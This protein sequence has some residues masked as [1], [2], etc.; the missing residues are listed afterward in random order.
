MP[1]LIRVSWLG[2]NIEAI[3]S[4]TLKVLQDFQDD[5]V[6]YL[7]RRMTPRDNLGNGIT[8]DEY[9]STVLECISDFGREQM[10]TYLILP[11]ER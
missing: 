6:R 3:R 7:E 9:V 4:S 10:A 5:E 1:H 8:K 2:N 11:I